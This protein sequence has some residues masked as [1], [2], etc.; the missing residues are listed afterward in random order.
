MCDLNSYLLCQAEN[1]RQT[2]P[3]KNLKNGFLCEYLPSIY[4][5][6]ESCWALEAGKQAAAEAVGV[7]AVL[8]F[9]VHGPKT[10][11]PGTGQVRNVT[12]EKPCL[13]Q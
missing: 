9:P 2:P 8:P 13:C 10:P 11:L 4:D 3:S 6:P 5:S 1:K 12:Q 7:P